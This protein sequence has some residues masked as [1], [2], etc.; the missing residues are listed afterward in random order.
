MSGPES[1]TRKQGPVPSP[2][3]NRPGQGLLLTLWSV[4]LLVAISI[5]GYILAQ[6]VTTSGRQVVCPSYEQRFRICALDLLPTPGG[7]HPSVRTVRLPP[8]P[9]F[10]G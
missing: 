1:P 2:V 9:E 3:S 4:Q 10:C 8:A 5:P 7:R 6:S